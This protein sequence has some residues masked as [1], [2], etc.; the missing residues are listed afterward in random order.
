[1]TKPSGTA[2]GLAPELARSLA[3]LKHVIDL[4]TAAAK[5]DLAQWLDQMP[6][7][8]DPAV[9]TV[10][11]LETAFDRYLAER[12]GTSSALS[13]AAADAL[14]MVQPIL[15]RAVQRRRAMLRMQASGKV[16]AL[17]VNDEECVR[18]FTEMLVLLDVLA[19][20]QP[21]DATL[22]HF[23]SEAAAPLASLAGYFAGGIGISPALDTTE[24]SRWRTF[25]L[26]RSEPEP[27]VPAPETEIKSPPTPFEVEEW[28][29]PKESK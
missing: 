1:M 3:D 20:S 24:S 26:H 6:N 8:K 28:Y 23:I 18:R 11:L 7:V 2:S 16:P 21:K 13:A 29:E 19:D 22:R 14:D 4:G 27:A 17:P 25:P 10:A 9:I 15:R 12:A 5:R